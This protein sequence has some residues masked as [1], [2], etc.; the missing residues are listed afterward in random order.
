MS[1]PKS[2]LRKYTLNTCLPITLEIEPTKMKEEIYFCLNAADY[3]RKK[4]K[5][6]TM[7]QVVQYRDQYN[8][9]TRLQKLL[10]EIV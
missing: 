2:I 7:E 1:P 8:L 4:R 3:L 5:D 9:I 6:D 10:R